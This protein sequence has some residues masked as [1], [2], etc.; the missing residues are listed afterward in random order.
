L[1]V[2]VVG[3]R[4]NQHPQT[5]KLFLVA[6]HTTGSRFLA[7]WKEQAVCNLPLRLEVRCDLQRLALSVIVRSGSGR[8]FEGVLTV[9]RWG[10]EEP[11]KVT[12]AGGSQRGMNG[13]GGVN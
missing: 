9:L 3:Q 13:R 2:T 4:G 10:K 11:C 7:L 8:P 5:F 12:P 1:C 6:S